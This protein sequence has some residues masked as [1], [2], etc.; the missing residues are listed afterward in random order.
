MMKPTVITMKKLFAL[1]GNQC[2]FPG[3]FIPIINLDGTVSGE[4]CHIC[5]SRESGSRYDAR[6]TND[7]RRAF[8][9]L[10]LLCPVHHKTVDRQPDIY[11]A[12]TLTGMKAVH[13][14]VHS[15]RTTPTDGVY[16]NILINALPSIQVT[17]NKGNVAINSP[18]AVQGE[19]INFQ[20]RTART[21]VIPPIGTIGQNA[22]AS[23]YV[24]YLIQR[25]NDFAAQNKYRK[26]RFSFA[27][28]GRNIDTKFGAKWQLLDME[29][30]PAVVAYIQGRIDT[31]PIAK[32]NRA[33]GKRS[34][35]SFEEYLAKY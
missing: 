1:S 13:E 21:K 8:A 19:I 26:T 28:L 34:Y 23:R 12:Q 7:Q 31:T 17:D 20:S 9:N 2:A 3:C 5:A 27:A 10:I 16:A 25:H 4:V 11:S 33:M 24:T 6:Q 32:A 22:D 15:R 30:F 35:S 29:K 14:K 18:G